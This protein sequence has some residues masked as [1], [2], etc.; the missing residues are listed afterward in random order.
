MKR[1][2]LCAFLLTAVAAAYAQSGTNSPYSRFGL[3][4]LSERATGFNRGM[5]GLA[6]GYRRHNQVNMLNP[7]SYSAIDS[8]TFIFDMGVSGQITNFKEN[9]NSK[10]AKNA[11]FEYVT[12]GFRAVRNVGIALGVVPLTNVGY[13]YSTTSF[14]GNSTATFTTTYSGTGGLHEAFLGVGWQPVNNFSIGV[15]GSYLWGDIENKSDVTFSDASVNASGRTYSAEVK[16][17]RVNI[18]AQYSFHLDKNDWLTVGAT[19][20]PGHSIGGKP[21]C[22]YRYTVSTSST[23]VNDTLSSYGGRELKLKLPTE[24]GAGLAWTHGSKWLVGLDWDWQKWS[25]YEQPEIIA[26]GGSVSYGM[27]GGMYSDRHKFT[28]GTEFTPNSMSR[29]FLNRVNYRAGVSYATSYYKFNSNNGPKELSASIGFGIPIQNSLNNRSILNVS[30]QWVREFGSTINE[31]S[32][33]L[34]I[35]F[36]FNERWFAKWKVE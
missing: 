20:S 29:R 9:G 1:L 25:S 34:T 33:R 32:F 5:N 11:N 12:A 22:Y 15:N 7:A 13:D 21:K 6:M 28:L 36:T 17:Y 2:P 4:M 16:S 31:N 24:V 23:E 8:L 3:G 14:I 26:S 27:R 35:G 19:Y 18:G 10:N 30:G